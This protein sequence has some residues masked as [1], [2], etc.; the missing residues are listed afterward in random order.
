MK[1]FQLFPAAAP[2]KFMSIGLLRE[3]I[4][5]KRGNRFLLIITGLFSKRALS[6]SLETITAKIVEKSF[7][8]QW[9][10]SYAPP[11]L[12]LSD[13]GRQFTSRFFQ[14]VCRILDV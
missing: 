14:H 9:V 8:P 10:L 6:V 11:L 5:T 3:I 1:P 4:N 2:L 13:N 7:V 12:F